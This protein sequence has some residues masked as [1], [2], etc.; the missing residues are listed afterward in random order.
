MEKQKNTERLLNIP[1]QDLVENFKP[2]DLDLLK[3][4]M[5]ICYN[6]AVFDPRFAEAD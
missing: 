4:P 2:I 5:F 1:V 6:A 3:G